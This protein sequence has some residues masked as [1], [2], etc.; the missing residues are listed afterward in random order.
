M[1]GAP[2]FDAQ[3]GGG[4]ARPPPA[5]GRRSACISR[6]RTVPA[7]DPVSRRRRDGGF[8][9]LRQMLRARA[10]RGA[11]DARR[12]R[13]ETVRQIEAFAA[14]F[15]RRRISSM[16]TSTSISLPQVGDAVLRVIKTQRPPPGC[17]NAG[18]L[19]A[20]RRLGRPQGASARWLSRRLRS[21]RAAR[22]AD[23]SGL[24]RRL[25]IS[26]ARADYATLF[27]NF[28]DGLPDGGVIMCHP[29]IVDAELRGSTR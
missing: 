13:I 16:G 4:A 10:S 15:G 28:L 3:R 24:C 12:L 7:A 19:A 1:V 2:T 6:Y 8:L 17:A 9:P 26:T 22:R 25:Y 11:L 23:Q 18:D 14:A 20:H 29:G 21:R 5:G 27:A